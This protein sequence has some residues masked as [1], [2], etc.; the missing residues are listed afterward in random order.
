MTVYVDDVGIVANVYNPENGRTHMS[1]WCHLF[2]DTDDQ[3]ELHEFA[4]KI[5]LWR[6][7]FQHEIEY[8]DAP[9][10]W[11]YD[12]NITKRRQAV[13]AGVV[14]ITWRE[15]AEITMA[16]AKAHRATKITELE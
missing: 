14:E 1:R 7:W 11:H 5:G 9:W 13:A 16:R 8:P 6:H 3:T 10:L 2:C 4:R 15:A 12:V